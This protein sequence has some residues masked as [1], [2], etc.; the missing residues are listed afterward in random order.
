[1]KTVK[2][3]HDSTKCKTQNTEKV[4]I[5]KVK[6]SDHDKHMSS[7]IDRV[8]LDHDYC[9]SKILLIKSRQSNEEYLQKKSESTN[10]F[11]ILKSELIKFSK[12]FPIKSDSKKRKLTPRETG[13]SE[14]A[15]DINLASDNNDT[16]NDSGKKTSSSNL[17]TA[18]DNSNTDDEANVDYY[19]FSSDDDNISSNCDSFSS[20]DMILMNSDTE[21]APETTESINTMNSWQQLL[22]ESSNSSDIQAQD[23]ESFDAFTDPM[24]SDYVM[25]QE[26]IIDLGSIQEMDSNTLILESSIIQGLKTDNTQESES[27]NTMDYLQTGNLSSDLHLD[28]KQNIFFDNIQNPDNNLPSSSNDTNS[29]N[30]ADSQSEDIYLK[31]GNKH[32]ETDVMVFTESQPSIKLTNSAKEK[33]ISSKENVQCLRM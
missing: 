22:S 20:T 12:T 26:P 7:T 18:N 19:Y 25:D 28:C 6:T 15:E 8:K 14:D 29:A 10:V 2:I 16:G 30:Q 9:S 32:S 1:M 17:Y 24:L 3:K 21:S 27:I 23:T 13:T 11:P 4:K 5:I 33:V 31:S